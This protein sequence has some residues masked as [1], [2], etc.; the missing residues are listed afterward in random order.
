MNR[1]RIFIIGSLIVLAALLWWGLRPRSQSTF[2]EV[3]GTPMPLP[4][5][6]PSLTPSATS[7][8]TLPPQVAAQLSETDKANM[9]K[10]LKPLTRLLNVSE[11][12]STTTDLRWKAQ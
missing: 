3:V 9:G 8:T 1:K 10:F 5:A 11:G 4:Q 7:A 6:S 12:F 2:P